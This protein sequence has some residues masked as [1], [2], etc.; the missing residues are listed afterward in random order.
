MPAIARLSCI[1]FR[2]NANS[3]RRSTLNGIEGAAQN[4]EVKTRAAP[5]LRQHR[6]F[7]G[8]PSLDCCPSVTELT[9]RVLAVNWLG[10]LIVLFHGDAGGPQMFYETVCLPH[11]KDRPCQFVA[12]RFVRR[13]RCVQQYSYTYAV[14]CTLD[15]DNQPTD[16]YHADMI[17][18]PSGCKC[19]LD[20]TSY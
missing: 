1:D 13:S 6:P 14:A 12:E 11:V 15:S 8:D 9:E 5:D 7:L 17:R 3:S 2:S 10:S 16:R 4:I 18:V 19:R 20:K